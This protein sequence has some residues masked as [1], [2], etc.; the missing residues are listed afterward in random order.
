MAFTHGKKAVFKVDNSAAA[1]QDITAYVNRVGFPRTVDVAEVSSLG[2]NAKEYIVGLSDARVTIEGKFDPTPDAILS[3]IL[4]Q[5]ASVTFEYGPEGGTTGKVRFTG[6]AIL[7]S[8]EK[9]SGLDDASGFTAEF[10]VTGA[11]TRNTFP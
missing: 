11:V 6:E 8:Y 4:G 2:D 10:Q 9:T 7:V 3:G 5:D 1:L